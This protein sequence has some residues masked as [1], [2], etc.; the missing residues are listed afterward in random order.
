MVVGFQ[1]SLNERGELVSQR[2]SAER[3]PSL[4]RL[5]L[6]TTLDLSQPPLKAGSGREGPWNHGSSI[7]S[8]GGAQFQA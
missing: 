2:A 8:V 7:S 5:I 6:G 1:S 3:I 4:Q